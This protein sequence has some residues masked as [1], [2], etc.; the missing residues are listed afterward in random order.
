MIKAV[1]V[2]LEATDN[3]KKFYIY[4]LYIIDIVELQFAAKKN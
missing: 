1:K 2:Y 3:S 4:K